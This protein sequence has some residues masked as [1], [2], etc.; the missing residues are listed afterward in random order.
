MES[1][2]ADLP[3]HL[4]FWLRLVSNQVS[5]AFAARLMRAKV[6]VVEWVAL[7]KLYDQ[8]YAPSSLAEELGMTRGAVTK[9]ADRLIARKLAV[10]QADA[11]DGRAQ[12]LALTHA[13]RALV[14]KLAAL[15]DQND[16]A[17]F[18]FLNR[19]ERLQLDKI[20]RKI[21]RHHCLRAAPTE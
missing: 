21:A 7:R 13:G 20:L 1:N 12:H 17:F 5:G 4:G 10:R 11:G 2:V 8:D 15:A 14:P 6:T 9:L 3:D 19:S 16:A 18:A